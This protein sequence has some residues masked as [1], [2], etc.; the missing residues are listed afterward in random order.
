M[1]NESQKYVY[2]LYFS[3]QTMTEIL[4]VYSTEEKAILATRKIGTQ[5]Q[6]IFGATFGILKK[7]IDYKEAI[8]NPLTGFWCAGSSEE[9]NHLME[10]P[11]EPNSEGKNEKK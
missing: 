7:E 9:P 4:G 8:Y 5:M 11:Q 1:T 6:H 2:I 10:M 3:C